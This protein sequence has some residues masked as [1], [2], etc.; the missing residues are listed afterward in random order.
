MERDWRQLPILQRAKFAMGN[1]FFVNNEI[2]ER[3]V[4]LH[5]RDNGEGNV[6]SR[7][8]ATLL[9]ATSLFHRAGNFPAHYRKRLADRLPLAYRP[10]YDPRSLSPREFPAARRK[11]RFGAHFPRRKATFPKRRPRYAGI[12][13]IAVF[14]RA[15]ACFP[16]CLSCLE[17]NLRG[18][19]ISRE[20]G[21]ECFKCQVNQFA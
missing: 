5:A 8:P 1:S 19:R 21:R 17:Q 18:G 10:R 11:P 2:S 7:F 6:F 20:L 4:S 13:V 16:L 9:A 14:K 15:A 3:E 12:E